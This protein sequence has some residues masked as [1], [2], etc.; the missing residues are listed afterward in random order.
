MK[1]KFKTILLSV[2]AIGLIFG[3]LFVFKKSPSVASYSYYESLK[4]SPSSLNGN[5]IWGG[6][7][8]FDT[9]VAAKGLD[10]WAAFYS[11]TQKASGGLDPSGALSINGVPYQMSWTGT[12]DY[13][14]NDT[15]RLYSEH[16]S[17][18]INLDTIGAYEHLYVLGTAGGPGE[19][20]YAN[21]AVRV[22]YTDGSV[23]ETSYRLY[24]WY[25]ATSVSGVYKWPNLARRLVV[26]STSRGAGGKTTTTYNYEGTTTGSP[27]LQSATIKVDPKK[28]VSSVDLV[29]T[30]K[31]D[32][33]NI[34]GIYCGIYAVTG[35]VNVS[36][37]NPVETVYVSNVTETTANIYWDSVSRATSYRLDIALDP[38]FKNILPDYNNRLVNDTFLLAEGLSGDTVYYTRVRAEN[39]EGQ[40]ISS[41]V[42]D[43]HT[44][45][46]TQP[47]VVTLNGKPNVIQINDQLII[48]AT[49]ISGVKNIEES[50]DN[51]ETWAVIAEGDHAEK[52]VTENATYCY[53]ASDIYDNIS[54]KNCIT[55]NKLDTNKPVIRVNT[56]GYEEE[57]WT[58]EPVTLTLENLTV[59][60]GETKYY[61]STNGENWQSYTGSVLHNS[62]TSTEGVTYYFKAVSEAG[63]ESDVVTA[64]VKKDNTA[65]SGEITSEEN[66]W[67]KFF[68]TVTFG[69]FFN[70][71]V[72]FEISASDDLSGVAKVEYLVSKDV[73]TTKEEAEA[74][75]GWIE[76]T[77]TV[78]VNPEKD[79]VIY[80]KLTDNVGNTSVIN[81]DG[82]ILDTTKALIR[83][84]VN[85]DNIYELEDD[86]VY[87]LAHQVIV[88]DNKAIEEIKV[89]GTTVPVSETN[90][91]GLSGASNNIYR[92]EVTDKAGNKSS[93][94]INV[95]LISEF[96][97]NV[98]EDNYK[99][100]DKDDI[101]NAKQKLEEIK[102][103]EGER[104]TDAE[105]EIIDS[106]ID[107]Y[108]N[109]LEKIN[110]LEAEITDEQNRGDAIPDIDH[111]T[112]DNREDIVEL[113]EDVEATI[114]EDGT[115]LT[116]NENNTLLEEEQELKDKL[117]RLDETEEKEEE[118]EIVN[119]TDTEIIKT[120]D[121]TELEE[122]KETA[123]QLLSGN[124][125]TDEERETVEAEKAIIDELLERIEAAEAAIHTEDILEV[126]PKLPDNYTRDDKND[127]E[128]AKEDL[129][130]ALEEYASNYTDEEIADILTKIE[131]INNAL[132]DIAAQE[133]EEIRQTTFPEISVV[134]ETS[135]WIS[136]DIAGISAT[137]AY[138]VSELSVSKDGGGSWE[139]L[140][141]L[142]ST[143]YTVE[144]NG[145]Y[146]FRATNTFGNTK[147]QTV[148]YHNIDSIRPEVEVESYGYELGSWT[149]ETVVLTAQNVAPNLSP[150]KIYYKDA[151]S[152]EW[153]EYQGA[154]SIENDTDLKTYE[155]KAISSAGLESEIET[156][157]IK[158]DSVVPTASISESDNSV[159]VFLNQITAGLL[160]KQTKSYH[161][162]TNDDRSGVKSTEYYISSSALA[163][164]ELDSVVWTKNNGTVSANPATAVYVYYRITDN[165]GNIIIVDNNGTIFDLPKTDT[166]DIETSVQNN[167][168]ST[169]ILG[170]GEIS[171]IDNLG[172]KNINDYNAIEDAKAELEV[173]SVSHD[174]SSELIEDVLD[175]YA[176]T[177]EE[178][179]EAEERFA[180]IVES[181]NS[182]PDNGHINSDYEDTVKNIIDAISTIKTENYTHLTPEE[183]AKLEE[184]L[185]NL[186]QKL[187]II[188][189]IKA[190]LKEVDDNV[191]N[192]SKDTVT[193]DD[194]DDL[195]A[196][197]EEIND[198]ETNPNIS[199]SEQAHLEELEE[200]IN[201]YLERIEDAEK[202]LEKAKETDEPSANITPENVRPEDQTTLENAAE[203]YA[204]ALGV[205]DGNFSLSDLFNINSRISIINSALDVLDQ[206]AEFENMISR[207]PNPEDINYGSRVAVKAAQ[208]AYNELS[209]YGRSLV[210][211]SLMAK[212]RAVIESYRIYLEGS[213]ILYAFETLDVFWWSLSTLFIIG[214]FTV[215]VRHTRKCYAEDKDND[216]F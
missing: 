215:A 201:E 33:T 112:S 23:D 161:V 156:A 45:N 21:F 193:S 49:D 75:S 58:K 177:L 16:T 206:V 129:E 120:N 1:Y 55:Y 85:A 36:A 180:I 144:E 18:R 199:E 178:I 186:N 57:T 88:T 43:F 126:I 97:I 163:Q 24:D 192:Y 90:I 164:E 19:G 101:E 130:N 202:A 56:N 26:G 114:D 168:Y 123:E 121:K 89:N 96:D 131:Q 117:A 66:S 32:S 73:F 150:V 83:G 116:I 185:D 109:I 42:V 95:G 172:S 107:N 176:D 188:E 20:N 86:K 151:T 198:L 134:S 84:Y 175:N 162:E 54:D 137:D 61:Y 12:S 9:V 113:L 47:P 208:I 72:N 136:F 194:V 99:T 60:V 44:D 13:N 128:E 214:A 68:N 145:T 48:T 65:P 141:D 103:A 41:N 181:Y 63:I 77:G 115:H 138:G 191:N 98:T 184:I 133:E 40:S 25:D 195:K 158:K 167:N 160:F 22:N 50:L 6:G 35:M 52:T 108:E 209:E 213:P 183:K 207:L 17:T 81:S 104:G 34:E 53:R 110:N 155:F 147:E 30:G 135:R 80:Y 125:L 173:Y 62:E 29:L 200:L 169:I 148:I 69:L 14:G 3:S 197:L 87:Y 196:L 216:K 64:L 106:L 28:L 76:A 205:F 92:I 94:A 5:S 139:K 27:Y 142:S 132:N 187:E 118:I 171:V 105:K 2:V 59:N 11:A 212:Y 190:E 100:D 210:G 31:N 143:T 165:A 51:G 67:N 79:F 149:N 203:G 159:A 91:I 8:S 189:T 4:I 7:E 102:E 127:L 179:N 174:L 71:T 157:D 82:I 38:D 152:S 146:I 153:K 111:V 140:S 166:V 15:I 37:P 119:H 122:L 211:P 39:S 10:A 182:L 70:K 170:S 93:M 46:E 124:N 154:V 204:E 78:S 74:A